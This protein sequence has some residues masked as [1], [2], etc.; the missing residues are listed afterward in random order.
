MVEEN[1]NNGENPEKTDGG[2]AVVEPPK[3]FTVEILHMIKDAQQQHGLR[4]G[5]YQRY[6][7]YCTRRIRRLR[8]ALKYPQGDKRHFKRR[9]VTLTQL[10]GKK[11]DERFIH[12]PLISSERAWAYAMQ[13]KQE[14]NT[15]PRKRFHLINKLRRAC[16]YALQLQ[17]LCNSE[18][19][20]ARTKLE[21]EA[22]V[23]WMHGTLHFELQLW[24]SAGEH[25]K[26]AQV[27]YENLA[28][29]LP[30]DE[31]ELYRAKVNEFAPNLRY[32]AYNI[33]GGASGGKIDEILE[34]R[35]Q[36]VLENLDVLVSQTKTESS[37]GLQT[38]DWRGRKVTVRPEK[39]RLF[40]LSAQE[41]DKS[42]AKTT[43]LD[44]KIELIERILMDCKDAIQAV[45]DEI[46][47]DPKLRSLTTGQTVSGVQYLLAYL[48]YIRHSR[49]LQRNLC[50]VDQAKLNFDD[51]NQKSQIV[52]D[53]K[54]VRSQDLARLYEIILQNVTEMQ[55]IAGME[56]DVQYQSEVANLA[57]TFKAFRCY[58]IALT[59]IDMKK[60]KE[61]VALYERASNYATEA[62]KGKSSSEF[63]MQAELKQVV[64]TIDGCKFSAHAYSVLEDDTKEDAGGSSSKSQKTTKPLYERLS[65][66]K[67]DQPLHTKT[68]NVFKLTPDMEPIPCKPLFFDL[69]MNYMELPSL[70]SK[71]ESSG[72]KGASITG[73]V[74]GFLGWGG[75]GNK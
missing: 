60:W 46:K 23:A 22:Y 66:Y 24:K 41:L 10:T 1:P 27:V 36:G 73:F 45:R 64:S 4:H 5:D 49:T 7:G 35:A 54:R 17:E 61:A 68:P 70:E 12:I 47:Q 26:R 57:I 75:G 13:L 20:D 21:C 14:A 42:L 33:S 40:L 55:Q 19:F 8:K 31:Q 74:K 69:A 32:C 63:Q 37:E 25:L 59:L 67:E 15:E 52:G 62:L 11:A 16:F 18:V 48:S 58:Y 50:L 2:A 28:K 30:D 6:R 44:G 29:A 3:I 43:K 53:G 72:K 71:L 38:I 51:P 65:E 34:L 56:E 39:V 9:D